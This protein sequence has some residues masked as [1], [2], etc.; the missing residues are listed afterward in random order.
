MSPTEVAY[1]FVEAIN[2]GDPDRISKR[3]VVLEFDSVTD[4]RNWWASQEYKAPKA[5]RQSASIANMI[6]AEGV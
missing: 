6:V 3:V 4:A 1:S 2:S 5:L